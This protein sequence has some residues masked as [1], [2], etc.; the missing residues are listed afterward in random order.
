V[1]Y[2]ANGLGYAQ[3][4]MSFHKCGVGQCN[5]Q[6]GVGGGGAA[7]CRGIGCEVKL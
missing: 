3:F 4:L 2:T 7:D 1:R 6:G 5:L